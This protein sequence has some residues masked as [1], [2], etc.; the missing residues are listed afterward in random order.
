MAL[1]KKE[2]R[3]IELLIRAAK[4]GDAEAFGEIYDKFV[5]SIYRYIYYRVSKSEAED[6]TETVF[7]R[8]WGKCKSYSKQ[9]GNSFNSWIF[10]I[11]HNVVVDHYRANSKNATVE[12]T[13][14]IPLEKK[15]VDPIRNLE[16]K[17]EQQQLVLALRQL[18]EQQQQVVILKFVNEMKNEEIAEII[19]KSV[20]AVRVIQFRALNRLKAL[21]EKI[22]TEQSARRNKSLSFS[23]KTV[24][25]A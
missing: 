18:P 4:K 23:F 16:N 3:E 20:G 24:E 17:F 11:A 12:L 8:A 7:L 9:K 15:E 25:D 2:L 6:L 22:E 14:D 1:T 21:L 19:K 5:V 13:E 10:R